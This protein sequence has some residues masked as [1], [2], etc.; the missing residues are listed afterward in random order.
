M[1][2]TR[3]TRKSPP[4]LRL[5]AVLI[6]AASCDRPP[7]YSIPAPPASVVA[8]A[9]PQASGPQGEWPAISQPA[10]SD[11]TED[12]IGIITVH[13]EPPEHEGDVAWIPSYWHTLDVLPKESSDGQSA[14]FATSTD[15][16]NSDVLIRGGRLYSN[17][18]AAGS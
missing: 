17:V 18:I 7:V 15:G 1:I 6:C 13:L 5:G 12:G 4:A 8:R 14:Y 11:R 3:A 16:G 10:P 9:T 2:R